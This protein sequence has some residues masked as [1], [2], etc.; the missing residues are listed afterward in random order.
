MKRAALG[1][2]LSLD[3]TPSVVVSAQSLIADRELIEEYAPF[4]RI[5]SII[6]ELAHWTTGCLS[7]LGEAIPSWPAHPDR[8]A[9]C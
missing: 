2:S 9:H 6:N 3:L 1:S 4:E 5:G 7:Q 8:G